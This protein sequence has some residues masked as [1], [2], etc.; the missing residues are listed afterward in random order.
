MERFHAGNLYQIKEA[1]PGCWAT[2]AWRRHDHQR[3]GALGFHLVDMTD[4]AAGRVKS[5][6]SEKVEKSK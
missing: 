3:T 1:L 5:G 2:Q 4:D 6:P